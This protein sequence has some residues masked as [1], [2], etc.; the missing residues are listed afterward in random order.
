MNLTRELRSGADDIW[1][2]MLNHPFPAALCRGDL[3]IEKFKRYLLQDYGYL[4]GALQNF[5][6]LASRT[7]NEHILLDLVALIGEE[8]EGEIS[9]YQRFIAQLGFTLDDARAVKP[10]ATRRNYLDFLL[11]ASAERPFAEGLTA[12]LPCFWSY[13]EIAE[14]HRKELTGAADSPLRQWMEVYLNEEYHAL[15]DRL[16]SLVETAADGHPFEPLLEVFR[17]ASLWELQYWDEAWEET[18]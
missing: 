2:S 10:F 9:D 16:R 1:R 6:L 15:V 13:L 11:T 3:P 4:L 17:E 12:T 18:R 7:D 5:C 14:H 8:A